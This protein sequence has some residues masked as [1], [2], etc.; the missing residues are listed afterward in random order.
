MMEFDSLS[1][2]K[3]WFVQGR[4]ENDK[5]G[6]VMNERFWNLKKEKQDR[7]I[8]A[9]LKVF[10]RNGYYR[11]CTDEIVK[12]AEIS[13]GLLF[14]YFISKAGLYDFVCDY[15]IR[16][17][18]LELSGMVNYEGGSFW[19]RCKEIEAV[20][21]QIMGNY[22]YMYFFLETACEE[23]AEVIGE[24]VKEK[25]NEYQ[26][27][28]EQV[29]GD[30]PESASIHRKLAEYISHGAMK[31][32]LWHE[33]TEAAGYY[34]EISELYDAIRLMAGEIQAEEKEEQ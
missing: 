26:S 33:D 1:Q 31:H 24:E 13:K 32:Y 15:S 19:E 30:A 17:M 14:H 25:L 27:F 9:A 16:Y 7:M 29:Y 22:P 20:K 6:M 34:K 10:A 21:T 2:K 5:W 28:V 18:K 8:N 12:E 4:S 3:M 23:S 11:A